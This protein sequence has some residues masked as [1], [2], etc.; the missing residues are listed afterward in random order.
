MVH[1][2]NPAESICAIQYIKR[3]TELLMAS[4]D[5][6]WVC[7]IHVLDSTTNQHQLY[8][9][10]Q[11]IYIYWNTYIMPI[12]YKQNSAKILTKMR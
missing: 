6:W 8:I 1:K 4:K 9:I 12:I 10:F 2:L 7:Y 5:R 11:K 3:A